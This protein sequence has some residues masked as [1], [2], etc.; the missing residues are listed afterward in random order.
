MVHDGNWGTCRLVSPGMNESQIS[1]IFHT[2]WTEIGK[3]VRLINL[4][5]VKDE[6]HVRTIHA[7]WVEGEKHIP[8]VYGG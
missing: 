1:Y 8:V 3:H 4:V 5:W 7:A 6:E 2:A